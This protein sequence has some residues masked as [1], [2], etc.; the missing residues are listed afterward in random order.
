MTDTD[1]QLEHAVKRAQTDIETGRVPDFGRSFA[2]AERR[3]GVMRRR[4]GFVAGSAVAAAVAVVAF[5]SLLRGGN[6]WQYVDEA[7]LLGTTSWTAPSDSLLPEHQFDIYREIPLRMES[8][9]SN[10]GAL[11]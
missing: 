5:S 7:E 3:V 2:A 6:D 1:R 11:L 9:G 8:T 10:E 4:R